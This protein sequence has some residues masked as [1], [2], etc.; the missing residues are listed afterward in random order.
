[1]VSCGKNHRPHNTMTI[2]GLVNIIICM[3]FQTHFNSNVFLRRAW[4]MGQVSGPEHLD[5][6]PMIQMIPSGVCLWDGLPI[7]FDDV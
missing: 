3:G 4:W 5:H 6:W 2:S 1:M 7:E